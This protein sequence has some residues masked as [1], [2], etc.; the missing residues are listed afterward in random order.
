MESNVLKSLAGLEN[1]DPGYLVMA[2]L[3]LA[4]LAI[5]LLA[6]LII[7]VMKTR[8][9][10]ERIDRL[11]MGEGA[12]SLEEEIGK[13]IEDN[14]YLKSTTEQHKGN[15]KTLFKRIAMATQKT[16]LVKYDA[17]DQMGGQ[18]SFVVAML[19]E[20][21]N[22]FLLNSVHTS[23]TNYIYTKEVRSGECD[24]ELGIEEEMALEKAKAIK[25]PR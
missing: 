3:V 7:Y 21:D 6:L 11:C 8:K 5:V 9:L 10:G 4:V 2:V 17:L 22:G 20:N 18:L 12:E 15:I 1:F 23:A 19:D 14:Q 24:V 13:I 25:I 16:A